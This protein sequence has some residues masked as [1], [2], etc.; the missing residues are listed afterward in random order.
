MVYDGLHKKN[1]LF[2]HRDKYYK[3]TRDSSQQLS[4]KTSILAAPK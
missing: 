2:Q 1:D 4:N 3:L